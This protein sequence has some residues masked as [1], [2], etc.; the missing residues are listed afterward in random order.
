[1][2]AGDVAAHLPAAFSELLSGAGEGW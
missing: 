1:V 2:A